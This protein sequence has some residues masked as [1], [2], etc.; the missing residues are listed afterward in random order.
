MRREYSFVT[1]LLCALTISTR[2][3][4]Y[5]VSADGDDANPGTAQKPW[6]TLQHASDA[7]QAG[8]R[9][10]VSDGVY[11]GFRVTASGTEKAR[12]VFQSKN[13]WGAKIN[14][15]NPNR[16]VDLICVLSASYV[17][18]DGFEVMNAPRAGIGV[19]TLHDDTGAD[20][21]D[22][23][24]QNCH[25]HHNG[26]PRGGAHDGIFSGFA[27]NF[28]VLNNVVNDNGEH[29]IY[30]SNSADNPVVRGNESFNNRACGIQ[31]NADKNTGVNGTQDGLISNWLVEN[32]IIHDNGVGGGAGI[33]LDGDINGVCRNNLIYNN[34]STG[35]AVYGIDGAQASH[36]NVFCSNTIYNPTSTRS[37]LLIADGANNNVAFN[38]IFYTAPR[39]NGIEIGNANGFLHDYNLV[40]SISGG[41]LSAHE[42]S[43]EAA[44]IFQDIAAHDFHLSA[45]SP[46]LDS[47]LAKAK[48]Y[49]A[50]AAD[51]E[52]R[53]RLAGK[54]FEIGCYESQ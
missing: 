46:A 18:I 6:R 24:I 10:L 43:P 47:G 28:Q 42:S 37:A 17:T 4:T 40:S 32:N 16:D 29:G 7:V 27:L 41:E 39:R 33:N 35:I 22:V 26:L 20:T 25:S 2:A 52:G 3:A 49:S 45:A 50:P 8:D 36:D 5:E 44:A 53:A 23:I 11:A 13:K 51:L 21:R 34:K 30:V 9:V 31:L 14:A 48:E 38:N 1:L 12:I 54:G 15:P 19:R